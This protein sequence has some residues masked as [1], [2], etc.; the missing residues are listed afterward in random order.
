MD[1]SVVLDIP[2]SLDTSLSL[3]LF[4]PIILEKLFT[5]TLCTP[6]LEINFC[7]A[8]CTI[9]LYTEHFALSIDF[10]Q[11]RIKILKLNTSIDK[12]YSAVYNKSARN[13]KYRMEA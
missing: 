12:M 11:K 1:V 5:T 3:T 13:R 10:E 9:K 4:A 7:S 2:V 8:C 6:F